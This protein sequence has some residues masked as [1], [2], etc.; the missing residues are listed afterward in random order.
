M[1]MTKKKLS[2]YEPGTLA[3]QYSTVLL[4]R[5]HGGHIQ[6]KHIK[7]AAAYMEARE[8]KC[9]KLASFCLQWQL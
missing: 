5:S 7:T 3:Q 9:H 4:S 1:I 6:Q 2:H 8:A